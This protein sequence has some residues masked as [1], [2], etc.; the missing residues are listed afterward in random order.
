M[1][2]NYHFI[3]EFQC[4]DYKAD[5][6]WLKCLRMSEVKSEIFNKESVLSLSH[7]GGFIVKHVSVSNVCE[8]R[9]KRH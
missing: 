3:I 4:Q 5:I 9:N 1:N 2:T 7:S 6:C 8:V